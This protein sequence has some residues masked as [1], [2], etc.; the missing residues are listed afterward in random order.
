[1][2]HRVKSSDQGPEVNQSLNLHALW[3]RRRWLRKCIG[4]RL[5]ES[6]AKLAG[7]AVDARAL[8]HEDVSEPAHRVYPRLCA[9]GSSMTEGARRKHLRHTRVRGLEDLHTDSPAIVHPPISILVSLQ[10]ARLKLA[11]VHG[12]ELFKGGGGEIPLAFKGAAVQQH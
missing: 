9:P 10:K 1:M 3:P 12:G 7:V 2:C 11:C 8:H 4:C 6:L 5:L